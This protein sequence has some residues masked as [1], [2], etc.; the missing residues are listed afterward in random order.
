MGAPAE[1][2]LLWR[3]SLC[4][5]DTHASILQAEEAA[6]R[7]RPGRREVETSG[8]G[9]NVFGRSPGSAGTFPEVDTSG[10]LRVTGFDVVAERDWAFKPSRRANS[11]ALSPLRTPLPTC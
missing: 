9:T 3:S 11:A 8:M 2:H 1:S 6:G 4:G 7:A 5:R 10:S